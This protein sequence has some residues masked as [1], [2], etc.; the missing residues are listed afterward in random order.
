MLYTLL[1]SS[2]A[3]VIKLLEQITFWFNDQQ[4]TCIDSGFVNAYNYL[5]VC[6][7]LSEKISRRCITAIRC[8]LDIPYSNTNKLDSIVSKEEKLCLR[9]SR[10]ASSARQTGDVTSECWPLRAG[11]AGCA[12]RNNNTLYRLEYVRIHGILQ[13]IEYVGCVRMLEL[14]WKPNSQHNCY[15]GAWCQEQFALSRSELS[16]RLSTPAKHQE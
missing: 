6:C 1:C 13:K 9:W 12:A 2:I 16:E 11:W 3:V 14:N 8:L 4:C 5:F 10:V 15:K 7:C